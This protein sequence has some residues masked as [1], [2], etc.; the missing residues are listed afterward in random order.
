MADITETTR[1]YLPE[2]VYGANDGIVTTLAVV[3]GVVG[4][5]LSTEIILILGFANLLADGISMGA[6]D[7]LSER[8][9]PR[10]DRPPLSKAARNGFA[11]FLGFVSA[12]VIPLLAY[13]VPGYGGSRFQLAV[14]LAALTLFVVGAARAAFMDRKWYRAGVEMLVIGSAAGAVAYGVGVLGARLTGGLGG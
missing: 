6:S 12:G 4:A 13:L 9:K 3:A 2:L 8:S 10:M 7:V 14:V 5:Q 11:T 1:R